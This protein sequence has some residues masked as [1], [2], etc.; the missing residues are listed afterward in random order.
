MDYSEFA[1]R[2]NDIAK[3]A[4]WDDKEQ[5]ASL[6]AV[7]HTVFTDGGEYS[8]KYV[9]EVAEQLASVSSAN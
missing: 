7:V 8:M 5:V 6:L 3:A 9:L 1:D 4:N 2:F